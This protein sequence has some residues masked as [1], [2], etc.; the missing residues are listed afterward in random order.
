MSGVRGLQNLEFAVTTVGDLT[1]PHEDHY[2]ED[3]LSRYSQIRQFLPTLLRTISVQ[4]WLTQL[5]SS[6][7]G[8]LEYAVGETSRTR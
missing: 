8:P 6:A 1:R 4:R 5:R 7:I 3:L 2:Y